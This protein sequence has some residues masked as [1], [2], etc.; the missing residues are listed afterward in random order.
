MGRKLVK[1]A[2]VAAA[3]AAVLSAGPG[4]AAPSRAALSNC[5][6]GAGW[7]TLRPELSSA[8]LSLINQH[9]TAMGLGVLKISPRLTAAA[10]WKSLHM[11]YY[12]YFG[13]NDPAP[14]VNRDPFQRMADCGYA[15]NTAKGE[16]IA[17]GF[18]TAAAVV[19]AWLSSSGHRGNIEYGGFVATGISAAAAPNGTIYWTQEFGGY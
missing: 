11:G 14:P 15:F 17:Y 9:R 8:A 5:T 13:H 16:N 18:S 7:G 12:Q 10:D 1:A 4:T 6:P 19:S 3:L 2:I